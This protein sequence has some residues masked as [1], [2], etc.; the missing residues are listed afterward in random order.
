M[1]PFNVLIV[2]RICTKLDLYIIIIYWLIQATPISIN[3]KIA[4]RKLFWISRIAL[5]CQAKSLIPNYIITERGSTAK[6]R[7]SVHE[8]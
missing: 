3:F 6:T 4:V 5:K 8:P 2:F 7:T 1:L